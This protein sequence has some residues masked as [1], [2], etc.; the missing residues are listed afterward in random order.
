MARMSPIKAA[1]KARP[2]PL[3]SFLITTPTIA[4]TKKRAALEIKAVNTVP[5][6]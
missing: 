3:K 6:R 5:G 1:I 2:S 4:I